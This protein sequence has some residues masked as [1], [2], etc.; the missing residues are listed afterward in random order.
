VRGGGHEPELR[1][2]D[3]TNDVVEAFL[4]SCMAL[5]DR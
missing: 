1:E 2:A 4:A 3:E 5:S